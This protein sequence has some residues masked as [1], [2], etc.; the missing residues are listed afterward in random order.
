VRLV[1]LVACAV[2]LC[3]GC[4][5]ASDPS[6]N[7][8]SQAA[9]SSPESIAA[10]PSRPIPRGTVKVVPLRSYPPRERL[11]AFRASK[12]TSANLPAGLAAAPDG[13][14]LYSEFWAGRVRIIRADGSLDPEPWADVNRLYGIR[15]TRFYHGGLSGIAFD[16]EFEQ[17]HF[18]Y[19]VT[20]TPSKRNGLPAQTIVLRF[21]EVDGR[22]RSPRIIRTI[23]AKVF[24]NVY[25]LVFG[26]DGMLYIPSGF[27]GRSRPR[28]EDPLSDPRGKILRVTPDGAAPGDNPFGPRAPR[29]WASGFKNAFDLAFVPGSRN[30]VAGESG[31]EAH[32][33]INL[34]VPGHDYGYPDHQGV[35]GAA[36]VTSPLL[37]YGSERTSPAGIVHYN[38]TRYPALR[39]RYLMCENHGR[40]LIALRVRTKSPARLLNFTPLTP[41][42]TIDLVQARDGSIILSDENAIYRLVQR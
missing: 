31:P 9:A 37:D 26:P 2:L 32:D 30:A 15:W 1:V 21:K 39:G 11:P 7:T 16:P 24:D 27:L 6:T 35:T 12:I 20:Q 4:S 22:G 19:V 28:G 42:C 40:G 38:G 25:S 3:A 10:A 17:N 5:G 41:N 34:V 8:S 29:V 13:R 14:I 23:R 18:V 36:G 33:E